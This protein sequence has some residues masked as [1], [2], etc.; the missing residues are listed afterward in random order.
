[1]P[2]FTFSGPLKDTEIQCTCLHNILNPITSTLISRRHVDGRVLCGAN[3]VLFSGCLLTFEDF[4]TTPFRLSIMLRSDEIKMISW[5]VSR[6]SSP[7]DAAAWSSSPAHDW[8]I[9]EL[10]M[11][12]I[13]SSYTIT[14]AASTQ[15]CNNFATYS[16]LW[17]AV[18]SL[19]DSD[20]LTASLGCV[21]RGK[22][23][24]IA[25]GASTDLE[26]P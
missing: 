20:C 6:C 16:L 9:Y 18:S 21:C 3:A 1:M 14:M 7:Q 2:I 26:S 11:A 4:C 23:E 8:Q 10:M 15:I 24:V 17:K 22:G 5:D 13:F 25:K 19:R 12:V